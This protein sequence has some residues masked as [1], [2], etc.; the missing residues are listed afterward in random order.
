MFLLCSN[1]KSSSPFQSLFMVLLSRLPIAKVQLLKLR[2]KGE[3]IKNEAELDLILFRVHCQQ[4]DYVYKYQ[5]GSDRFG[6]SFGAS[7]GPALQI[8]GTC[9]F[10]TG[11]LVCLVN[12]VG[13]NVQST[14][15][16]GEF[17]MSCFINQ[18]LSIHSVN[19]QKTERK[20]KNKR[21]RKPPTCFCTP[22]ME[23]ETIKQIRRRETP[24]YFTLTWLE[25][26]DAC[27]RRCSS[28]L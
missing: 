23:M 12:F 11:F 21:A 24:A 9:N 15:E 2:T 22:N 10:P 19:N 25:C 1:F 13:L 20:K 7:K 14:P 6:H 3:K 4:W 8:Q 26:S 16:K 18:V 27:K 17:L 5:F 28:A